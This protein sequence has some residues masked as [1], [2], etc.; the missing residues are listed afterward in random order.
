[1]ID[2]GLR[3]QWLRFRDPGW[4]SGLNLPKT[5]M[6]VY[7]TFLFRTSRVQFTFGGLI[8]W[9]RHCILIPNQLHFPE[10][11]YE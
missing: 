9:T 11:F 10:D 5:E 1:M 6:G 4:K 8:F 7:H 2:P 3:V